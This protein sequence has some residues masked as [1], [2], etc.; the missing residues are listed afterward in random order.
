MLGR[1]ETVTGLLLFDC[2][3]ELHYQ[4]PKRSPYGLSQ[5]CAGMVHTLHEYMP[6]L[7]V[8]SQIQNQSVSVS[9]YESKN[10]GIQF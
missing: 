8:A 7:L 3:T 5:I 9:Q 10:F 6:Q 2:R 1:V 4:D